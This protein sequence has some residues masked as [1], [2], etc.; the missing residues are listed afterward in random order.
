MMLTARQWIVGTS[1]IGGLALAAG[2]NPAQAA[3][4]SAQEAG[5]PVGQDVCFTS[6]DGNWDRSL[7]TQT[8]FNPV[9]DTVTGSGAFMANSPSTG[10][11]TIYLTEAG[12][13]TQVSDILIL[14]Y[15]NQGNTETVTATWQSDGP[16]DTIN[17]GTVPVGG[18]SVVETGS[19]QEVTALLAA[20]GPLPSNLTVQAQSQLDPVPLPKLGP[21]ASM[22]LLALGLA[23]LA[24][25]GFLRRRRG[26]FSN[27]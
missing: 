18:H 10:S 7:F 20:A 11:S 16:G 15:T 14:T 26:D 22:A 9:T 4:L 5:C 23:G 19:G 17:L 21:A 12:A 13:P 2:V 6:D 1:V 24:G 27:L 3:N 8:T 25:P